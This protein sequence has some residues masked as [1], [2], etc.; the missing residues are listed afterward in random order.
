MRQLTSP[1]PFFF[2]DL[3]YR[4]DDVF[5]SWRLQNRTQQDGVTQASVKNVVTKGIPSQ[6]HSLK[7]VTRA[8][9]EALVRKAILR[10]T[11]I[12]HENS[13]NIP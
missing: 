13:N 7:K 12:L 2:L 11:N 6:G 4:E 9:T 8:A 5:F 3:K 1:P 10:V